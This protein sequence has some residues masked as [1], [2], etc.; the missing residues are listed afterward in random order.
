MGNLAGTGLPGIVDSALCLTQAREDGQVDV[1]VVEVGLGGAR[2]A[3]NVFDAEQLAAAV[4]T[5]IGL[6]HAA[7]LGALPRTP[8]MRISV[9]GLDGCL[10]AY[11]PT[12]P[13]VE[14]R[15]TDTVPPPD[16][17]QNKARKSESWRSWADTQSMRRVQEVRRKLKSV[18]VHIQAL[19]CYGD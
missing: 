3:T 6:E 10:A 13:L 4:I 1:A 5:P 18:E 15:R 17:V 14:R 11:S 7:A 8:A 2:D 16:K 12:P 19:G 9:A